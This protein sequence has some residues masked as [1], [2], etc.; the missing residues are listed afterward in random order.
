MGDK[1]DRKIRIEHF[2]KPEVHTGPVSKVRDFKIIRHR[3]LE[4]NLAIFR[5]TDFNDK[6]IP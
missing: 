6:K 2:R 3:D 4:K 5:V 1:F